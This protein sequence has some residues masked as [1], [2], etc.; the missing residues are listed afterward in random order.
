MGIGRSGRITAPV[1][2]PRPRRE[3]QRQSSGSGVIWDSAGTIVTNAHVVGQGRE[4]IWSNFGMAIPSQLKSTQETTR[5]I[6]RSSNSRPR[7]PRR[8]SARYAC[9]TRRTGHRRGKSPRI[10]RRSHYRSSSRRGSVFG[11]WPQALVRPIRLAPG[12]SGGPFADVAGHVIGINTM[13]APGG[14][15]L[16]VPSATVEEFFP[17]AVRVH[18]WASPS[19][20]SVCLG[21]AAWAF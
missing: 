20:L 17:K 9:K 5:V 7:P 6:W 15:A 16:A 8:E 19:T 13:L 12:N 10:H 21:G 14:I 11:L 2:R 3:P 1:D 18:A 4:H